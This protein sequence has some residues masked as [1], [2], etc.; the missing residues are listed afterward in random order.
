MWGHNLYFGH[1]GNGEANGIVIR[2]EGAFRFP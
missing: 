2:L 1:I